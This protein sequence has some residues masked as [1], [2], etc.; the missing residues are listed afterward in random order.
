[1]SRGEG[2]T[3]WS[4]DLRNDAYSFP[5]RAGDYITN[6]S[7]RHDEKKV[8]REPNR[9]GRVG[10]AC[11]CFANDRCLPESLQIIRKLLSRRPGVTA[12]QY[13]ERAIKIARARNVTQRGRLFYPTRAPA[14]F[15]ETHRLGADEGG[16]EGFDHLKPATTASAKVND[17]S[18]RSGDRLHHAR[19]RRAR[20][21]GR[22]E[23]GHLD[24]SNI[25]GQSFDALE[26][27]I[28]IA[29]K[30]LVSRRFSYLGK[31]VWERPGAKTKL[32]VLVA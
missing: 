29:K 20:K 16:T 13:E 2:V 30:L 32:E 17:Q 7:L 4:G 24:V 18:I 15:A 26:S 12:G 28:L 31:R 23:P 9:E 6:I 5:I 21:A 14:D 11:G 1:M 22:I 10:G 19:R 3:W 27:V 8:I 25:T